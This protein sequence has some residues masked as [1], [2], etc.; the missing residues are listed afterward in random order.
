L[1][2]DAL[3]CSHYVNT[4]SRYEG[5]EKIK[6]F[7]CYQCNSMDGKDA[8]Q[9]FCLIVKNPVRGYMWTPLE[10]ARAVEFFIIFV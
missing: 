4:Y 3:F 8:K 7:G 5:G 10:G 1:A 2:Q 9:I 6:A